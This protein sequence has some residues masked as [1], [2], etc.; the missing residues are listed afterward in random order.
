M[1][2]DTDL[3]RYLIEN[4]PSGEF[5]PCA[6]YDR[7]ADALTVFISNEPEYA[8]RLNSRVTAYLSEETDELMGCRIK[9]VRSVLEDIGSFDVALSHG[10][11]KLKMLFVALHGPFASDPDARDAY[12]QLGRA[13]PDIELEVPC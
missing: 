9:G 2:T 3:E 8:K 7:D 6:H 13:L 11:I 12:R 10:R 4:A 1:A 5:S